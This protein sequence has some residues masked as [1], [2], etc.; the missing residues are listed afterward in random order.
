MVTGDAKGVEDIIVRIA[1]AGV[2]IVMATHDLG[3]A[4]RVGGD[5]VFLVAGRIIEQA[6]SADF[7]VSPSTDEA[8]RFLAGDLVI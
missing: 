5:V 6:A 2:K 7:F 4:R 3:Q 1:H 8:R